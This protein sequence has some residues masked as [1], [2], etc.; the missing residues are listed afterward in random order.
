[1]GNL[2]FSVL[3]HDLF[4]NPFLFFDCMGTRAVISKDGKPFIATHF[5]GSPNSLGCKLAK[6]EGIDDD[7]LI[8]AAM[9]N[10][11][12]FGVESVMDKVNAVRIPEIARKFNVSETEVKNGY[13]PFVAGPKDSPVSNIKNYNDMAEWEYNLN[14]ATGRFQYRE[15]LG[16]WKTKRTDPFKSLSTKVC[17]P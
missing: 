14:M 17:R 8:G 6:L 3:Q 2:F 1:M 5:D 12:D 16:P 10:T 15:V 9:D 4:L 13:Q 7:D 11:I